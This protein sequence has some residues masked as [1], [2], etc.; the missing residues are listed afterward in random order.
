MGGGSS[1]TFPGYHIFTSY[2]ILLT[3]IPDYVAHTLVVSLFSALIVVG[4]FLLMRKIWNP[5]AALIVAFLVGVSRFDIEMLMWGGFPNV[6]TLMLIPTAFYLFLEREKLGLIPFAVSASLVCGGIF[7]THSLSSVLFIAIALATLFLGLVSAKHTGERKVSLLTW[8]V[9][10]VLGALLIAPFLIQ[11]APAYLG[12]DVGTF[13]GGVADIRLALLSTKLLP[14]EIV[15]PLFVFVFLYFAFSKYYKGK[16]LTL[17]TILL[18]VWWLVPTIMTQGYLVGLYT[19]FQRFL[20]FVILPVIILV[21]LGFYHSAKFFTQASDWLVA[22]LKETPFARMGKSKTLNRL[23]PNLEHKNFLLAFILSLVLYT[24]LFVSMFA[25]PGQGI[26]I[27]TFYQLI[28]P[29]KYEA[30][31]WAQQNTPQEALF[32][33]DAQYGWWFGG[34]A[35][36]PTIS[37]VEPQYLTNAREFEPAKVARYVL[38]TDYLI[39]NGLIQVREDGG[40]IARHN[41]EF[42]IKLENEYFPYPFF[43]LDNSKTVISF[44]AGESQLPLRMELAQASVSDMHLEN[45]NET[46]S[47]FVTHQSPY[48]NFTQ[49]TTVTKGVRF[50]NITQELTTD[51]P[52][53]TF[54]GISLTMPTKGVYAQIAN[55]SIVGEFDNFIYLGGPPVFVAGQ[56]IFTQGQPYV[57]PL[58]GYLVMEYNLAARSNATMAFSLGVYQ[59]EP[60]DILKRTPL[61]DPTWKE[62]YQQLLTIYAGNY[63]AEVADLPME[64]FDYRQALKDQ[65]VAFIAMR[66]PEQIP[67]LA[68]D[69]IFS[70]VFINDEV[71]IFRVRK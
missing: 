66:D 25:Q 19:D 43:N 33:T 11:V 59:Y 39:D 34:F 24:T 15:V 32:L 68:K 14:L 35:K 4:A 40:Y 13:T 21:G 56:V 50:A 71:S 48:F 64:I 61:E 49:T 45:T 1:V 26:S 51:D 60:S 23:M 41:P 7:L 28:N 9:P 27:Q 58:T 37:A 42:L 70:L 65:K 54:D 44:R 22:R 29:P 2:I 20:Y 12:S 55:K 3:G 18:V 38:D 36:R 69:P 47:I 16:A 57:T 62:Y 17:S 53:V 31:T 63:T 46:A 8:I 5:S 10:L 67:R 52:T 6:V 30:L